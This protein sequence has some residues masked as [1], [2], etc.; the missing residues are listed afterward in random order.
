MDTS[1]IPKQLFRKF[2]GGVFII[3]GIGMFSYEIYLEKFQSKKQ[4][5]AHLQSR[6][7]EVYIRSRG[8]F[9]WHLAQNR[10][11]LYAGDD[12]K[13]QKG[14]VE[15][16][17]ERDGAKARSVVMEKTFLHFG[18][19]EDFVDVVLRTG[20]ME[21]WGPIDVAVED[22]V[23][24]GKKSEALKVTLRNNASLLTPEIFPSDKF[25]L[26]RRKTGEEFTIEHGQRVE[27][28]VA[29]IVQ[30]SLRVYDLES[31]MFQESYEPGQEIKFHAAS[32][33]DGD[34]TP[35]ELQIASSPDFSKLVYQTNVLGK[36]A[37]AQT[38]LQAGEYYWRIWSIERQQPASEVR[39]IKVGTKGHS[40]FQWEDE[41][42][43]EDF[44]VT[45]R[46]DFEGKL[47][48]TKL[49]NASTYHL[50]FLNVGDGSEFVAFDTKE[51]SFDFSRPDNPFLARFLKTKGEPVLVLAV[52][53]VAYD[54]KGIKHGAL[55]RRMIIR[56]VRT[57]PVPKDVRWVSTKGRL[58]WKLPD[59]WVFGYEIMVGTESYRVKDLF[60]DMDKNKIQELKKKKIPLKIRSLSKE[61]SAWVTVDIS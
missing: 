5:L 35:Y 3:L 22:L 43:T 6:D 29:G 4:V 13:T 45:W 8:S 25:V 58:E 2:F 1:A 12:L 10:E 33:K 16:V 50:K 11:A 14:S 51:S 24:V 48:W 46:K 17:W 56:D 41:R 18:R 53:I 57:I 47:V 30:A 28:S 26:V 60:F 38:S 21:L 36:K 23:F 9:S 19:R 52:E 31:P 32:L 15:I 20:E 7:A 27:R 54:E 49:D 37:S 55:N 34:V 39:E 44:L 42:K 40:V 59:P 61:P